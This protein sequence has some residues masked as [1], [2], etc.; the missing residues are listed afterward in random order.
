VP[1]K[2]EPP[3]APQPSSQAAIDRK[4]PAR[5]CDQDE[6][7][8]AQLRSNPVPDEIARFRS[9][10][11]CNRLHA[12]VQRLFESFVAAPPESASLAPTPP[13]SAP[14]VFAPAGRAAPAEPVQR[15]A[16]V[17]Q[18]A[19][20]QTRD[21]GQPGRRPAPLPPN[22]V[23]AKS[24]LQRATAGFASPH[25]TARSGVVRARRTRWTRATF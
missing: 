19:A 25:S 9:E 18:P 2:V 3:K 23:P 12:Q 5:A 13:I 7:R 20:C 15:S 6:L 10:L 21:L 4:D 8:L 11:S 17:R 14:P 22:P 1:T 24:T 16:P